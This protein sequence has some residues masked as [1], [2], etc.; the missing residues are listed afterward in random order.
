MGPLSAI[1]T[2]VFLL[3]FGLSETAEITI[4]PTALGWVAIIAMIIILLDTFWVN[5]SGR[6]ATWRGR[7]GQPVA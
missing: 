1:A 6:W 5:S 3:L 2:S 7:Q 4:K